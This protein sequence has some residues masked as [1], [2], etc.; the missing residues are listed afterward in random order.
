VNQPA[1][2][3]RVLAALEAV[4][5]GFNASSPRKVSMADLIVLAGSAGI[6]A[7]AR[8]AGREILVPFTPGRTDA[9]QEETDVESFEV[10]EPLTDG[11][12]NYEA[13]AFSL[14]PEA[15][16]VDRAQLLGLS[17]PE[18]T[19]LVGG[20]RVLGV[21]HGAAPE[22]VFTDR[23][24]VLTNDFFAGLVDMSVTWTP[25]ARNRY[26]GRDTATGSVRWTAS[27]V[28]L[29]FGSNSQLRAIAEVYAQDDASDRFYGDFVAAWT[30]VMNAD[31][32]DL[33]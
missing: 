7:A 18:M 29:A 21:N 26:E 22:G 10:L 14:L 30:K 2:L 19:V 32:F 23:P 1:E 25:V 8:A 24:G 20:L 4:Q 31:R 33:A 9:T 17:A 3:A 28:D 13:R 6:E 5:T 27:R 15:Q 16:L 12:R 11:F